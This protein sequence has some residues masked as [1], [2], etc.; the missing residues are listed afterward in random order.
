MK[1]YLILLI[2]VLCANV[3]IAQIPQID[4]S[5]KEQMAAQKSHHFKQLMLC[6]RLKTE[7]QDDYDAIYYA[8]D[9]TLNPA[10]SELTGTVEVVCEVVAPSME[11]IELNFWNGMTITDVHSTESPNVQLNYTQ[12]DDILSIMLNTSYSHGEQIRL[13]ISYH[14]RP[15]NSPYYSFYFDSYAGEPM[16]WTLSQPIGARA[17]WPCKDLPSDKPDSVDIRVTVPSNLTV[18]S[19]GV[20]RETNTIGNLTTYWWHENYPIVTY[21][22]S[23][24]IY[25][26]DVHYD[27]YVYN[28]GA[29]TMKIHFYNFP[30]N[31][32]QY[33]EINAKVKD[34]LTCYSDLFGEYPF[35]EEKYGQ[36]DCLNSG[37]MEHQTCTSY[38]RWN[39]SLFA[40][41]I[42]H[43]WWGDMITCDNWHDIWLNEGF[44][45]YCEALWFEYA[46]PSYTASKYQVIYQMFLGPGTIY[47]ENPETEQIFDLNLSYNKASWILHMLRHM[48]GDS[49]FFDILKTY[50]SSLEHQYGTANSEEFQAICE[51]VSGMKLDKFFHQWLHE[52]YFPHYSFSW[53]W[54]QNGSDYDIQL[55]IQQ[56]QENY[57][58]WMPVDITV[59]TVSGE[60][61]C[62]VWDS[63]QT[64]SFHFSVKSEPTNIELDKDNWVLK[65]IEE[66]FVEPQFDQGILLVNGIF[67]GTYGS[68]VWEAYE[69]RAFWGDFPISFWDCFEEPYVGY[70]SSLPEPL[71]YGGIP[72]EILSQF[73]TVIWIG[74]NYSGDIG[75]WQSTLILPYLQAGGNVLLMT[76]LGQ[77]FITEDLREYLGIAWAEDPL[78][79]IHNCS[80]AYPG[81]YSNLITDNQSMNAVFDT[82]LA[83][84]ESKLLFKESV[85]FNEPRGLGVW[86]K[87]ESGGTYRND[88]GQFVFISGRPYRYNQY[89]LRYNVEFILEHFFNESRSIGIS[90][91]PDIAT[92]DAYQLQQNYPNP[93]NASTVI[94]FVLPA[95]S[96]VKLSIF[97][98]IGQEVKELINTEYVAGQHKV[99]WD[100]KDFYG[101][102]VSSGVY[103]CVLQADEFLKRRKL[104]LLR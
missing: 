74:N 94:S 15:Q 38:G 78:T 4:N 79:T 47:V 59:T 27:D 31:Y 29:D 97:N 55:E 20:L 60:T 58:F 3:S 49:T 69:N 73:S 51:Q 54:T 2:F 88:G 72:A 57:I 66:P 12:S 22:V 30:G 10:N 96:V 37:G 23:L 83:T 17:W 18:A 43:Q 11:D 67:F 103:I 91:F 70:P 89:L 63:L 95:K 39:E 100:A 34:I 21:L 92:V 33:S 45:S 71:G 42:A 35:I 9:L 5:Y 6:E 64:Q 87:P 61:T 26:Y 65:I 28:S 68:E 77:D 62:V 93:F 81:L 76:R 32:D 24:A 41:E 101:R 86:R 82:T 40:H 36:A 84:N 104:T 48:V 53:N 13:V 98:L 56:L 44:A 46:Y 102:N 52:E 25:P 7:N 80:A 75:S 19:N 99:T 1:K 16:I 50:Y 14:G 85:S 8:L 90:E